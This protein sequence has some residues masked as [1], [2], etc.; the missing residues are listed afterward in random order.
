MVN[1]G[2]G[3]VPR[4][5]TIGLPD[6]VLGRLPVQEQAV[7]VLAWYG[8]HRYQA[9]AALLGESEDTVKLRMRSGLL[10]MR[11]LLNQGEGLGRDVRRRAA[12]RR[13]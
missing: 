10:R 9:A 8:R 11:L 7:I 3:H 2:A 13:G 12:G 5:P 1:S 4:G 6:S